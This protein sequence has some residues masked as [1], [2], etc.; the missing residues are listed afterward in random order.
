MSV[1]L[2]LVP[3]TGGVTFRDG[4]GAAAATVFDLFVHNARANELLLLQHRPDRMAPVVNRLASAVDLSIVYRWFNQARAASGAPL[5]ATFDYDWRLDMRMSGR[6]LADRLRQGPNGADAF[7]LVGHSQGGLVILEAAN[8][9]GAAAFGRLVRSVVFVG[10]PFFGTHNATAA[11]VEGTF[12]GRRIHARTARSWPALYQMM[13]RWDHETLVLGRSRL[14]MARLWRD[15]GLLGAAND[16]AVGVDPTLLRR[17]GDWIAGRPAR[18]MFDPLSEVHWIRFVW[19]NSRPTTVGLQAFPDLGRANRITARGDAT[20][21]DFQTYRH[22]PEWVRGRCSHVHMATNEHFLM[23]NDDH[24]YSY[25][26][27]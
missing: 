8:Q 20:V 12:F 3:G 17:G 13:P 5:W 16:T 18:A 27:P 14:F 10:T 24:V 26:R 19:G 2:L 7:H 1:A 6:R 9:L 25:C 21:A 15:A 23:G 4:D 11:L 22:L